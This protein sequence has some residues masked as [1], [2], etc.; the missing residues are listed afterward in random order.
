[1]SSKYPIPWEKK[2]DKNKKYIWIS[3]KGENTCEECKRLNGKI[4]TG[5]EVP[6]R[7]H[8]N[9]KCEVKEL[10]IPLNKKDIERYLTIYRI[11]CRKKR[12]RIKTASKKRHPLCRHETLL[13]TQSTE[14][15]HFF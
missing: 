13:N 4:F 10:S 9:C 15:L 7:P 8:P 14:C 11:R 6:P 12:P 2:F 5:D 1:M 3:E